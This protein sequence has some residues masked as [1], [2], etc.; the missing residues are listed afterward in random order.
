MANEYSVKIH[1]YISEKI[2]EAQQAKKA[3]E[4][5]NDQETYRYFE[6]RLHELLN[7]REYM[8]AKIDLKTQKYY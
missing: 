1:N 8:K 6:G 4:T 5:E 2:T 7:L 3:S